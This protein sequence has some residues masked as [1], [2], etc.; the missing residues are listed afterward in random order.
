MIHCHVI[1]IIYNAT[2]VTLLLIILISANIS[3]GKIQTA[4]KL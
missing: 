2:Y 1:I 3:R 4:K